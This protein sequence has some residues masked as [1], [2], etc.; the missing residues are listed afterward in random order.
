MACMA[1]A[2]GLFSLSSIRLLFNNPPE[3]ALRMLLLSIPFNSILSI[4]GS[5]LRVVE[6]PNLAVFFE[7]SGILFFVLVFSCTGIF[8]NVDLTLLI[9][10]TFYFISSALVFIGAFLYFYYDAS[11]VNYGLINIGNSVYFSGSRMFNNINNFALLDI[12]AFATYYAVY[13]I[14]SLLLSAEHVGVFLV[15]YKISTGFNFIMVA[16]NGVTVGQFSKLY[17]LNRKSDLHKLCNRSLAFALL[18]GTPLI[19][20]II[21][22][23]AKIL[24]AFDISSNNSN[25]GLVLLILSFGQ[26]FGLF[27]G[28]AGTLISMSDCQH[29]LR[30][31]TMFALAFT[32][33]LITIFGYFYGIIG[34]SLGLSIGLIVRSLKIYMLS[35]EIFSFNT[36][37]RLHK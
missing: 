1:I 27:S 5:Y 30:K 10:T 17:S 19:I 15:A 29:R 8:F 18:I 4:F 7:S 16:I 31:I 22:F 34:A 2:I 13:F 12:I 9:Y 35:M 37:P 33:C 23:H 20:M 25:A 32:L 3:D 26:F 36:I 6:R 28:S 24:A 21:F 14:I 11:K